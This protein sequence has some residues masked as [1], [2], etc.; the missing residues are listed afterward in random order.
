MQSHIIEIIEI[1][2]EIIKKHNM[3]S[4]TPSLGR[5]WLLQENLP[6]WFPWEKGR[7]QR[8]PRRHCR[9]APACRESTRL[10][11]SVTRTNQWTERRDTHFG[12]VAD[13]HQLTDG[14]QVEA[15]HL[16]LHTA[17]YL[18]VTTSEVCDHEGG[19]PGES[20]T[21]RVYDQLHWHSSTEQ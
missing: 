7:T 3:I 17:R 14:C 1:Q 16:V 13:R 6:G 21:M 15:V 18:T 10:I 9:V 11:F 8:C 19:R 20:D 5:G 2:L 4:V 12:H